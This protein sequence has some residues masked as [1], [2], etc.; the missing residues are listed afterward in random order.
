MSASRRKSITCIVSMHEE[1]GQS[2]VVKVWVG[3]L[4]VI[5]TK[6]KEGQRECF[7]KKLLLSPLFTF[8]SR[9][10]KSGGDGW[11]QAIFLSDGRR[12]V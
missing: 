2:P 4:A 9:R 12:A 1:E 8:L 5:W 10:R 11:V 6:R 7:H 3:G